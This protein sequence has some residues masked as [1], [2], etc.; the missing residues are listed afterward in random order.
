MGA[1]QDYDVIVIG[2]GGAGLAAAVSAAQAGARVLVAEAAPKVGGSTA[3]SG[4]NVLAAGTHIQ[5]AAGVADSPE[6]LYEALVLLN[7][8]L[9]RPGVVRRYCQ[10]AP[11]TLRWLEALGAEYPVADLRVT[12]AFGPPR[13]H[14]TAGHGAELVSILEGA[15]LSL[16]VEIT[17]NTR[18]RTLALDEQGH[19]AGIDID[20]YVVTAPAVIIATGGFGANA[21]MIT[22]HYPSAVLRPEWSWYIGSPNAQGDAFGLATPLAVEHW[23]HDEGL[24]LLTAD[25]SRDVE[26]YLPG[27]IVHLNRDGQR[28]VDET[29]DYAIQS[30]AVQRQPDSFCHAIFDEAC[31]AKASSNRIDPRTAFPSP[32]WREDRLRQLIEENLIVRADTPAGLAHRLGIE[33]QRFADSIER[34]NRMAV[35]GADDDYGKPREWLQQLTTPPYY[36]ATLRPSV[37]SFTGKGLRI[38][39]HARVLSGGR[40]VPGLFAAGEATGGLG[41]PVYAG[42]GASVGN[43]IVFGRIAGSSAAARI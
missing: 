16:G 11:A 38:D 28:F 20:G 24:L 32:N 30:F 34:Y 2:G 10:A 40:P 35:E 27:W 3:L 13:A 4:G 17:P 43:A 1:A 21:A 12:G 41:G 29:T 36:A 33:P 18:V 5:A 39:E 8:H 14:R 7:Q 23:G 31:L 25:F 19:V 15:A 22:A 26:I 9:T 6:R 42:N 37:I